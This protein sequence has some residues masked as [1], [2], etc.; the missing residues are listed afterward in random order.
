MDFV[1]KFVF[2]DE[3]GCPVF[4]R[5]KGASKYFIL[6]TLV[7]DHA[8]HGN[9]LL[10]LRRQL[11]WEGLHLDA[12]QFHATE[13]PEIIRQRVYALLAGLKLNADVTIFE[14]SKAHPN[15][16]HTQ[17]GFYKFAWYFHFKH[18]AR[19]R[20]VPGED[21]LIQAASIGTKKGRILFRNALNDVV[22]QVLPTSKWQTTFWSSS[23]DPCL[24]MADYIAWAVQRKYERSDNRHYALIAHHIRSEFDIFQ[25]SKTHYF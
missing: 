24:Q 15:K 10:A 3:A 12:D 18:V 4:S 25:D 1:V 22:Q 14:K 16:Y 6:C 20:I 11:A 21:V 2:A 23:S 19:N 13:D 7:C 5:T 17:E 9:E 8:N